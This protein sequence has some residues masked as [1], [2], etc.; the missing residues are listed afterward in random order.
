MSL[1]NKLSRQQETIID[2]FLKRNNVKT[3]EETDSQKRYVNKYTHSNKYIPVDN[4]FFNIDSENRICT[5]EEVPYIKIE[6]PLE[7]LLDIAHYDNLSYTQGMSYDR[8]KMLS[9]IDRA[10][11]IIK[12]KE[13]EDWLCEN[14]PSVK[15]AKD[16]LE[17]VK[18]MCTD[19][20]D[21]KKL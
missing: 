5:T 16:H 1:K 15:E 2:H 4:D 3:I 14:Y 19:Y 18:G 21:R 17:F 8:A 11:D 10:S 7:N 9:M 20:K 13:Y 12:K 6:L